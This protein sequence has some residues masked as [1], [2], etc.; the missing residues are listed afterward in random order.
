MVEYVKTPNLITRSLQRSTARISLPEIEFHLSLD[1]DT[2]PGKHV[3]LTEAT[4]KDS[5]LLKEDGIQNILSTFTDHFSIEF[6][7]PNTINV[8]DKARE[9]SMIPSLDGELQYD[10]DLD[11][12]SLNIKMH[13]ISIE[14]SEK[15]LILMHVFLNQAVNPLDKKL[16]S[17]LEALSFLKENG[18]NLPV[19][20]KTKE[21]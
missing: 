17:L 4:L 18:C 12:L 1:E 21:G 3:I 20:P 6:A 15:H 13:N 10:K 8:H 7:D 5:E 16:N 11:L 19:Y 14:V 9:I 2:D